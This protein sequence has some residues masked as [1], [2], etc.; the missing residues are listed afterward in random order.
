MKYRAE[1]NV[2]FN[3]WGDGATSRGDWHEGINFATVQKLPIVYLCNNNLY[4]YS[5]PIGKQMAVENV[6]DR[7]PGYDMPAEI[8]D[9]NDVIAIY[10]GHRAGGGTCPRWPGSLP[11]RVQDV[12]HERA[13]RP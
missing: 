11:D 4:A 2:V 3:Y 7:A 10:E 9:G 5:T 1:P 8:I 6:A 13:F 12:S